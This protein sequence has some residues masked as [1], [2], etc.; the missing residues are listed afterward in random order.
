MNAG[1]FF[2][3]A[4]N[5]RARSDAYFNTLE[6]VAHPQDPNKNKQA[7]QAQSPAAAA[8]PAAPAAGM[9]QQPP[10]QAAP[11]GG[12]TPPGAG[13]PSSKTVNQMTVSGKAPIQLAPGILLPAG[14]P[15]TISSGDLSGNVTVQV[16]DQTHRVPDSNMMQLIKSGHLVVTQSESMAERLSSSIH[17]AGF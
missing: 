16:G 8:A 9:P 15:A 1:H 17:R 10:A 11:A 6:D 3:F 2:R 13:A 5:E 12:T 7:P 4:L 14:T